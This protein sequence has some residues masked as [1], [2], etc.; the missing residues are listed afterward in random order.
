MVSV[1]GQRE[2]E[3]TQ[4][5]SDQHEITLDHWLPGAYHPS[6]LPLRLSVYDDDVGADELIGVAELT[7]AEASRGGAIR[8]ELRTTADVPQNVGTLRLTVQVVP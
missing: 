3:R 2:I 5:V 4:V 1:P 7:A 8:L 6:D